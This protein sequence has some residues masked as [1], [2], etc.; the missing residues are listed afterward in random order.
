M[1]MWSLG[2]DTNSHCRMYGPYVAC[3]GLSLGAVLSPLSRLIEPYSC[4]LLQ[5]VADCGGQVAV[6]KGNVLHEYALS[7]CALVPSRPRPGFWHLMALA[8]NAWLA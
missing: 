4:G 8:P 3:M 1:A 7:V 2:S 6:W 5:G